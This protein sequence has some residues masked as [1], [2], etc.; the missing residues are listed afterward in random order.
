MMPA[1]WYELEPREVIST[2]TLQW[3]KDWNPS[4]QSRRNANRKMRARG[5]H[6]N[7]NRRKNKMPAR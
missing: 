4:E 1:P 3:F 7:H 5:S 6:H 2:A